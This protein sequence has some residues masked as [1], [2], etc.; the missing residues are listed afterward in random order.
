[1]VALFMIFSRKPPVTKA[2]MQVDDQEKDDTKETGK[3]KNHQVCSLPTFT[4][5]LLDV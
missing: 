4:E 2:H 1:M 3:P 5:E